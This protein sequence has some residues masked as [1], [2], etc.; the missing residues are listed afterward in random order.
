MDLYDFL[1]NCL[2]GTQ[3]YSV[4]IIYTDMMDESFLDAEFNF[5]FEKFKFTYSLSLYVEI[6]E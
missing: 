5:E 3:Y 4:N 2:K 1:I 6:N